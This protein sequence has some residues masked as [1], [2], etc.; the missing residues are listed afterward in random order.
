MKFN[1]K[2]SI[3][4]EFED[5]FKFSNQEEELEHDAKMIMFR[6]L[7]ELEKINIDKSIKNKDLAE[8]F[9]S[10]KSY[11]TQLLRGDKLINLLKLAKLENAYNITFEIKAKHNAE[12][13]V[14]EINHN[15]NP[16]KR[17]KI[18][19]QVDGLWVF[20]SFK[21]VYDQKQTNKRKSTKTIRL[22]VA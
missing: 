5:L 15:Y 10:S 22:Q 6:F 16:E 3:N 19:H 20:H 21:S 14:E 4:P 18:N 13:Y 7:S 17:T 1:E 11:V 9:G 12:N 2:Y 8:I